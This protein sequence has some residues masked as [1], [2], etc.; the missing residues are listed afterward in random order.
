MIYMLCRDYEDFWICCLRLNRIPRL[1]VQ[2]VYRTY[3]LVGIHARGNRFFATPQSVN[4]P[5]IAHLR[6]LAREIQHR[7]DSERNHDDLHPGGDIPGRP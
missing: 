1:E 4:N 5:I 3:H 6:A 7:T 2:P